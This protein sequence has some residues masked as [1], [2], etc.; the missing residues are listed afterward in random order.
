VTPDAALAALAGY[1]VPAANAQ[2]LV[3]DWAATHTTAA[4]VGVLLPR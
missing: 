4:D 1:G 3:A 2:A